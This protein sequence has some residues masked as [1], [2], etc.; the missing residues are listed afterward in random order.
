MQS[1]VQSFTQILPVGRKSVHCRTVTAE[2]VKA[3][4]DLVGDYDPIHFDEEFCKRT[5]YG[6]PV[7]HGALLIGFMS[8]ASTAATIDSRIPMVSLGYDRIRLIGPVF[9]GEEARTTFTILAHD[10]ARRRIT[11][12]L[13][14][15]VGD[16]LV[17]VATNILKVID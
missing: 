12:E 10:E 17:A 7:A 5:V 13:Q 4:A 3:F 16:R 14:V 11:A 1:E 15:H 6:R 9:P 8:A 2:M